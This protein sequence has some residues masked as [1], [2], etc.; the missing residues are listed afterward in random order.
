LGRDASGQALR[1]EQKSKTKKKR[2]GRRGLSGEDQN[3]SALGSVGGERREEGGNQ[4]VL[5][6]PEKEVAQVEGKGE[7]IEIK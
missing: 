5:T 1:K 4:I 2:P 7:K 6:I 3:P